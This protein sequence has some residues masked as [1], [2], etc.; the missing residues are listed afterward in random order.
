MPKLNKSSRNE[1]RKITATAV[2]NVAVSLVVTGLIVPAVSMAYQL[3][4]PHARYWRLFAISWLVA[5][6]SFHIISRRILGDIE[7]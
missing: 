7:E 3:S 4:Y 2:N 5:G 1:R 6:L